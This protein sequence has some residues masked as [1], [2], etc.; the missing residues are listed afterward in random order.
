MGY[1]LVR[2]V[3][4]ILLYYSVCKSR[5]KLS[6][7]VSAKNVRLNDKVNWNI[8]AHFCHSEKKT[9]KVAAF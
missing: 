2:F 6:R 4:V 1:G 7:V 5:V 9:G 3:V 8:D